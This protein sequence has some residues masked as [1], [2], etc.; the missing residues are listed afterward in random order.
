MSSFKEFDEMAEKQRKAAEVMR[1]TAESAVAEKAA[2][3]RLISSVSI[4][5]RVSLLD[6]LDVLSKAAPEQLD[7]S[8][9]SKLR[10]P[11]VEA[12]VGSD[13]L[14]GN[15][16]ISGMPG[17]GHEKSVA[18]AIAG[19][20]PD[21]RVLSVDELK[22]FNPNVIAAKT[23]VVYDFPIH[24]G[25]ANAAAETVLAKQAEFNAVCTR[26]KI[27]GRMLVLASGEPDLAGLTRGSEL[28][29]NFNLGRLTREGVQKI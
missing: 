28:G 25:D 11:V 20:F 6:A 16:F 21:S 14:K 23:V 5:G 18:A 3:D 13:L 17:G 24:A 10:G 29:K 15:A 7:K 2:I 19:R 26:R 12:L 27:T 8:K 1:Q 22:G 4:D 9:A